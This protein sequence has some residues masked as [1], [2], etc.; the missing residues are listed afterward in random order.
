MQIEALNTGL[1]DEQI[2][3]AFTK[4]LA[5][6]STADLAALAAVVDSKAPL[7]ALA[8]YFPLTLGTEIPDGITA[9]SQIKTAGVYRKLSGF[10][11]AFSDL[12]ANWGTC[13]AG[14]LIV[15]PTAVDWRFRHILLPSANVNSAPLPYFWM[16]YMTGGTAT[17][18]D[19][20]S[21]GKWIEFAGTVLA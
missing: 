18:P 7:T 19:G 21:W 9:L 11:A 15:L 2:L 4:A 17:N 20:A 16:R 14:N 1:T 3:S 13:A 5:S 6:A 10:A 12:P 8:G